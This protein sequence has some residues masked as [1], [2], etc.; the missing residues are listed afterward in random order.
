MTLSTWW[1]FIV[2][3]FVVSATPG[4]NMLLVMSVSARLG[5]RAAVATML[6]CMTSLLTMVAISAAGLAALLQALTSP[7]LPHPSA[8]QTP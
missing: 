6:G 8:L 3:T 1:L 5:L 4:P 7:T 2:M